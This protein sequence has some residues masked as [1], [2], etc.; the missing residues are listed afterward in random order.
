M[1]TPTPQRGHPASLK[2]ASAV[3]FVLLLAPSL[4]SAP[5]APLLVLAVIAAIACLALWPRG[6]QAVQPVLVERRP[7]VRRRLNH[8]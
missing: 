1:N 8:P 3:L 4:E 7:A 5:V 2:I 6:A